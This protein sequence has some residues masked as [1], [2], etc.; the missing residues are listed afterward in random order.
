MALKFKALEHIVDEVMHH[1]VLHLWDT[2]KIK[3][4]F[5]VLGDPIDGYHFVPSDVVA[6]LIA[7]EPPIKVSVTSLN[8]VQ[9]RTILRVV[10]SRPLG[11]CLG[12]GHYVKECFMSPE[13]HA[14]FCSSYLNQGMILGLQQALHEIHTVPTFDLGGRKG[15]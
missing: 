6:H 1:V 2:N 3:Y 13:K 12:T 15:Y 8:P 9:G 10:Y 11:I 7:T 14:P 5:Q 4:Y